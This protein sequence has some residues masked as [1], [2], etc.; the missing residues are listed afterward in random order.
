VDKVQRNVNLKLQAAVIN[1]GKVGGRLPAT[2]EGVEGGARGTLCVKKHHIASPKESH[3]IN[4]F[5]DCSPE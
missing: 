5:S 3:K 2:V 1:E 4:L